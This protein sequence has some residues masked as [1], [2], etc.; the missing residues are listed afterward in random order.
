MPNAAEP[1]QAT[2]QLKDAEPSP[3]SRKNRKPARLI[4]PDAQ[5]ADRL[6]EAGPAQGTDQQREDE[7]AKIQFETHTPNTFPMFPLTIMSA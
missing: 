1:L 5:E 6:K 7:L 2:A 3:E 4:L